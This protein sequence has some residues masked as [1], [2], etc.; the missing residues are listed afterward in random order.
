[1]AERQFVDCDGDTWAEFEPGVL[2]CT[3]VGPNTGSWYEGA[4]S[5]IEYVRS[6]HG[7]LTEIRP[8][9]DVRA[10]LAD[11]LEGLAEDVRKECWSISDPLAEHIYERMS[12]VLSVKAR[13]LREVTDV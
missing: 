2:R 8:D 12:N 5:S 6:D 11:V 7:P 3:A 10:L 13:E 1:M 4:E 9:V